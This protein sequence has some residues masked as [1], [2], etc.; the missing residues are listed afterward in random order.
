MSTFFNFKQHINVL[1]SVFLC[2]TTFAQSDSLPKPEV[3]HHSHRIRSGVALGGLGTGS[4][5]LRK[6]G[7]FYNWS[8]F[9][10]YPSGTGPILDLPVKPFS[11]DHNSF[12]FFLVRYKEEGKQPKIKLLQHSDGIDQGG[13]LNESPIYYFPWLTPIEK[14]EYSARFPFV[15][16]EFSDN[17]MPFMISLE[18]F[19]PFIPHNPDDSSI[20]V[21]YFNFSITSKI[22]TPLEV[23]II[24]TQR[25]LVAFDKGKKFFKTEIHKKDGYTFFKHD[26]GGVPTNHDTYGHMGLG[27]FGEQEVSYYT[28]WAHRHPFMEKLLIAS[29]LDNIDDTKNRNKTAPDGTQIAFTGEDNNQILKSSIAI[30]KTVVSGKPV[31]AE[32]FMSWHFPNAYGAVNGKRN[33]KKNTLLPGDKGYEIALK[34]T[35]IVGKYYENNFKDVEQ[36]NSYITKN[37]K[38]LYQRT[39]QF[40]NDFYD[41]SVEPFILDQVN[42]QLNTLITSSQ[43]DT[44]GRFAI[45]E[46][47][48]ANQAW[49]P[50]G[51]TDVSLY[52]S[53]MTL[54]LFPELQKSMMKAHKVLQTE[55]GEI[56]HGLGFDLGKNKNGTFGVYERVDLAPNYIQLVLRDYLFTNDKEYL[57]EM[58]PSVKLAINYVLTE[59]DIDGDEMPNMHGIMCSYDNFPM[60]GLSSYIVTQWITA[61][62]MAA[63]AAKDMG[64]ESLSKK[65]EKTA[66]KGIGLMDSQLWNGQ[67]YRLSNDY[68]GEKGKDEGCLTDQLFGQWVAYQSGLGRLFEEQKIKSSLQTILDYSFIEETYLR[69]CTWPEHKLFYP[70]H[71]TNLWVD[72]ANTPWTGVELAFAAFLIREGMIDQGKKVIQAVD[73]RYRKAG[74]YWDHQEFGGHYYRPM[75]AWSVIDALSGFNIVRNQYTFDP[76][77]KENTFTYF[78]SANTGSGQFLK[79]KGKLK[80][81]CKQ[82]NLTLSSL[83]LPSGLLPKLNTSKISTSSNQKISGKWNKSKHDPEFFIIDFKEDIELKSDD[84]IVIE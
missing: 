6:D 48:T 76:K 58:W 54:S 70:M 7:N 15:N 21:V 16:M 46:G 83:R 78:F 3:S 29:K 1:I 82:G 12:L 11:N 67:Y 4:I 73:N 32:F 56:N 71:D 26:V 42:S 20:P 59:L 68:L 36:V 34:Q 80:V 47:M 9:N 61:L 23:E 60:Y 79:E 10:N 17:E 39:K 49:G 51:T 27:A 84:F 2:F 24:A 18:T 25:N 55:K 75:S 41:S 5:E 74:L 31:N 45:Q 63:I 44:S 14:I 57:S 13:L 19:S 50:F 62:K 81:I 33:K 40:M 77:T 43:F 37:K 66:N 53:V 64:E 22:D 38:S 28:G 72:Q 69:N 8:I 65:Y 30:T 52:G 35:K